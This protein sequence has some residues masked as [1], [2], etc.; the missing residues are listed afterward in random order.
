LEFYRAVSPSAR[1]KKLALA[2]AYPVLKPRAGL[3]SQEVAKELSSVGEVAVNT[4]DFSAL[5]S[6]TRDKVIIHFHGKGYL[7]IATRA[8]RIAAKREIAVY[9]L[10]NRKKP[11][12]F[13]FSPTCKIA[14][15]NSSV[16]F[17]MGYA[18]GNFSERIPDADSLIASLSELF[19][20]TRQ[21]KPWEELWSFLQETPD[22]AKRISDC[23]RKGNSIVGLVHRDFKPWNVKSGDQPL[24]FDFESTVFTGCPLEDLFNYTVEPLLRQNTVDAARKIVQKQIP[25]Q[26][27]LLNRLGIPENM[28]TRYY[29]YYLLER[30]FF[31]RQHDQI[32]LANRFLA[33]CD[34]E[35]SK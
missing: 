11:Q 25:V 13:A 17:F 16:R 28:R 2:C 19:N 12:S 3:N 35:E 30:T 22:L 32:E 7:K 18:A 23:D 24:F 31:W 5:I 33:L 29:R 15:D 9:E 14:S 21:E 6:P 27:S 34:T 10:L 26:L 20:L 1:V 4:E 8:S